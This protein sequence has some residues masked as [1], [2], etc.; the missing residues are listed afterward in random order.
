MKKLALW[1]F[2]VGL[3][4]T[5]AGKSMAAGTSAI[6]V[7]ATVQGTCIFNTTPDIAFGVLPVVPAAVSTN[8]DFDLT[9]SN[10]T[11]YTLTDDDGLNG[12]E[13]MLAVGVSGDTI[14]YTLTYTAGGTGTG[15]SQLVNIVADIT[16]LAYTG[17]T[18][19][20]YEDTVTFDIN[21]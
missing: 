16:A 18:P 17:A 1:F 4:L 19:D 8:V 9:C 3:V 21:P 15:V 6:T 12:T 7:S 10:G 13:V 2:A 14:D 11:V 5:F 20:V